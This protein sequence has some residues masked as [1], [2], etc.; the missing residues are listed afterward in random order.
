MNHEEFYGSHFEIGYRYGARLAEHGVFLLRKLPFP[1]TEER[2]RFARACLPAYRNWF[3]QVLEEIE[4]LARGQQADAA[5][6]QAVLFSM[7]AI[8]P[9]CACSCFAVSN[10]ENVLLGRNS[11][12]W[13]ALEPSNRNVVY[14]LA[15]QG[16]DFTGNTTA[17]VEMEDGVNAC[18][19]AAGLT[20]VFPDG[21]SPGLN[22]G[23]LLRLILERCATVGQAADLLRAAPIG[24]AMTLTLADA[25]G[26][27]LLAEC[28][29]GEAQ[30][31]EVGPGGGYLCATNAYH[32]PA[33]AAHSRPGVDDWQAERRYRTMERALRGGWRNMRTPQ[34]MALLAGRQGFLCQ[35][36]RAEGKDTVW[37]AVYDLTGRRI[38]RAEGNPQRTV[39]GEDGRFAFSAPG[40]RR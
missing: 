17:F 23:M 13:T 1:V 28:R 37:S 16:Y 29:P 11:D 31:A 10:G 9:C 22:A 35:Y 19:L 14:R 20:S 7:Y 38:Y 39:F 27:L 18:G 32:M 8:P 34:A 40:A 21:R 36:D 3:P 33:M 30:L 4:G 2:L 26:R 25:G 24:S 12:F 6:L 15:G 5:Q